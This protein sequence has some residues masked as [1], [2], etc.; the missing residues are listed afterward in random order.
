MVLNVDAYPSLSFLGRFLSSCCLFLASIVAS[1]LF[2]MTFQ[3]I[4][5]CFIL[6]INE[7]S[8]QLLKR[9]WS[10][11]RWFIFPVLLLHLLFTSGE[12]L[13]EGGPTKEGL[14]AAT[15]YSLHLLILFLSGLLLS[16]SLSFAEW[17]AV[18]AYSPVIGQS[19]HMLL[20]LMWPMF[21][22]FRQRMSFYHQQWLLRKR[23][24]QLPSVLLAV[25][26][27]MLHQ[28]QLHA[29]HVWLRWDGR[30]AWPEMT[31]NFYA[32]QCILLSFLW[33]VL[34]WIN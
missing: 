25:L 8:W 32:I 18:C 34:L 10:L 11:L 2:L 27:H 12:Y 33:C 17:S 31:L 15:W 16:R 19:L 6:R 22:D 30:V 23:W 24:Q 7:G 1:D 20:R 13:F 21:L 9:S 4:L 5:L 3:L 29:A 28:G 26:I 14:Y